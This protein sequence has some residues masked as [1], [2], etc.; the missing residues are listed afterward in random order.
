MAK[1]TLK[2]KGFT[3]IE[4][5][6]VIILLVVVSV[7]AGGLIKISSQVFVDVT[8]RDELISSV[9]YAVERLNREIRSALPNS[10]RTLSFLGNTVQCLEYIPIEVSTI[11][12]DI[13]VSPEGASENLTLIRFESNLFDDSL[14]AVVYPLNAAEIYEIS[15]K[16][17]SLATQTLN[18]SGNV[19]T[20]Q[21]ST[22]NTFAADSPTDRIYFVDQPVAYCASEGEL[23]RYTHYGYSGTPLSVAESDQEVLMAEGLEMAGTLFNVTDANL[24]RNAEVKIQLQFSKNSEFVN[25]YN[26]IQVTNAP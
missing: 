18:T 16:R 19:W 26:K 24:V 22:A 5:I 23:N 4:L 2:N 14:D 15:S 7:G 6:I 25:F 17:Y 9:R 1:M 8:L 20:V 11:Y 13:P 10:F 3:L 21:L 12:L